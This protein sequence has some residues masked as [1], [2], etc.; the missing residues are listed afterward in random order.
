MPDKEIYAK[1]EINPSN[2]DITYPLF[3]FTL[4]ILS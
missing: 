2:I 4:F 3:L 1:K